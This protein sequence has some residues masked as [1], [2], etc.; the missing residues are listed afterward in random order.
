MSR[1]KVSKEMKRAKRLA[2]STQQ[3]RAKKQKVLTT[4]KHCVA[5]AKL[6]DIEDRKM[7]VESVCTMTARFDTGNNITGRIARDVK[8]ALY[9]AARN[10]NG[11]CKRKKLFGLKAWRIKKFI[12]RSWKRRIASSVTA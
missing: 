10:G 7:V 5:F 1:K 12:Q 3:W 2:N 11:E 6:R 8:G 9:C 4:C